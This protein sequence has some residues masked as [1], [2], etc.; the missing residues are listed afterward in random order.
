M[1]FVVVRGQWSPN[2]SKNEGPRPTRAQR[3]SIHFQLLVHPTKAV[4][5][6]IAIAIAIAF[7]FHSGL[8]S[9]TLSTFDCVID[10]LF[11]LIPYLFPFYEAPP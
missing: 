10:W 8:Q 11:P 7:A 2:V 3:T 5:C 6:I 1:P 9:C 4:S